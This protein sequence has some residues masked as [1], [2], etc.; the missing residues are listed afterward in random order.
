M[1]VTLFNE[2]QAEYT[3]D[4]H[5]TPKWVFDELDLEFDIDVAAPPLGVP[6]IPCKK[7]Y[8]M[9]D[10]GLT[11]PWYGRVW[12]NPPFTNPTPWVDRFI[13]HKNGILLVP[14][15]RSKWFNKLW[16]SEA[17]IVK[18]PYDFKFSRPHSEDKHISFQ[19]FLFAFGDENIKA[20]SK[21]GM[22]R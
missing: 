1:Q 21:L 11:S 17:K 10:D 20:I 6:W 13:E 3:N 15:S 2:E 14:V 22:V 4:D 7:F 9:K 12:C 5:Y 19:T 18:T 8:T 16:N